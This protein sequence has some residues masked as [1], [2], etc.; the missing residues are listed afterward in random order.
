[1]SITNQ[2][3][4]PPRPLVLVVGPIEGEQLTVA[5]DVFARRGYSLQATNKENLAEQARS[6]DSVVLLPTIERR[7]EQAA[8]LVEYGS[9]LLDADCRIY[10]RTSESSRSD[11]LLNALSEANLPVGYSD[12]A[13]SAL[14]NET[15]W[16]RVQ[17]CAHGTSWEELS[18]LAAQH[19]AGPRP[20]GDLDIVGGNFSSSQELLVRRAFHDCTRVELEQ[21]AEGMSGV[22]A[23]RAYASVQGAMLGPSPYP[24]FIKVGSR[25]KIV[26]EVEKY[27][28]NALAYIPFHLRPRLIERRCGLGAQ[29]GLLVCDLVSDCLCLKDCAKFA[30]VSAIA[31]LFN[32][33]LKAWHETSTVREGSLAAFLAARLDRRPTIPEARFAIA[34]ALGARCD[35]DTLRQQFDR[36]DRSEKVRVG[37]I[38]GDLHATN[39][40][41]RGFDAVLID[42][43]SQINDQ[44]LLVDPAS[45]EA[46]LLVDGFC[47]EDRTVADI[48]ASLRPL[49]TGNLLGW[50]AGPQAATQSAWFYD[51]VRQIRLHAKHLECAPGQYATALACALL[52]KAANADEKLAQNKERHQMRAVGYVLA[53]QI[54]SSTS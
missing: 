51:C 6:A 44:P 24:F 11:M 8:T 22:S 21:M 32:R 50:H 43:E 7:G 41:V 38:H 17:V 46:G 31:S 48:L 42:F 4:T 9:D 5:E 37:A 19:P 33:T 54:L 2:P 34:Q 3:F 28:G 49:Y 16:P 13:F 35:F 45:L 27:R 40:M 15:Y 12:P 25:G 20:S 29:S 47:N 39:V 53:E 30:G 1:L 10:L 18:Q 52:S 23:Y 36:R 26:S 14:N